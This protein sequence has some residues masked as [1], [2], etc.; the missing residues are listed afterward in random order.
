MV[1]RS[2]HAI[3]QAVGLAYYSSDTDGIGG[4]LRADPTDFRVRECEAVD[5]EPLD[6]D[7]GAYPHV[8]FRATLT[9]HETNAFAAALSDRLGI[10]RERI[11]WAGT[12][13]KRAV[14]TQLFSVDAVEPERLAGVELSD[15]DLELLG[16]AGRAV[17]L[18]DLRGNDFTITLRDPAGDEVANR[19]AAITEELRAFGGDERVGVPNYFGQQRFGSHRPVTHRVGLAILRGD[20]EAAVRTYVA[21][22][23]ETEPT[24][25]YRARGVAG[26][27]FD[28]GDWQGTLEALPERL[29]YERALVHA[30]IEGADYRTAIETLPS[31]LQQLFIHAAQS[32]AF[33]RILSARLEQGL[34]FHQPVAGDIV[35]FADDGTPPTPDP[36]R[37]Q[38]VTGRRVETIGR[39]C[40]RD[41]A[42]VTAPLVGTETDLA[43]GDP[44]A[45]ER[46]V[47]EDLDI[48]PAD[49]DLP[50]E[51]A[52]S[53]TRRAILVRTEV[54]TRVDPEAVTFTF[55]LPSGAYA[56]VFLREYRK[57]PTG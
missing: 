48:S 50:D 27:R 3:E 41:R 43:E 16:R 18:G 10:S 24:A 38:R 30:L 20:W 13:D 34:P 51:W 42:F 7:P 4:T 28:A 57:Q 53:G 37:T 21:D 33:N 9:N 45:I 26:E 5:V 49:F 25:T 35:C 2:P 31:T 54:E 56:T 55:T 17:A 52:S 19:V 29:G 44:G 46:T 12:K 40:D 11:R 6:A 15:A 39:H 22:R 36:S 14:T 8:V 32:Y 47:L 1:T 23:A